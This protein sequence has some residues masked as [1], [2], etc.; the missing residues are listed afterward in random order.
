MAFDSIKKKVTD[1]LGDEQKTDSAL[2]RAEQFV[3]E[4]TGGKHDDKITKARDFVD[5][6]V[7]DENAAGQRPDQDIPGQTT[8][9]VNR[10]GQ[11]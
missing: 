2:D 11:A 1:V 3:S 5:D 7:G 8:K 9:G 10:P 4:K 6:K